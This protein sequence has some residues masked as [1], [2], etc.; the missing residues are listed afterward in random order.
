[1]KRQANPKTDC[2]TDISKGTIK[3]RARPRLLIFVVAF[4]AASTI[5]DVLA[6]IPHSISDECE[7]E[8]LIID[9][10]STDETFER[11]RAR[12][13]NESFQFPLTLLF[14]PQN[15]GYGG[16]QKIGYFYAIKKGFDFV[17]L[18]HGDGQYAPECLPDLVRPLA[19]GEADAVFGSRM[20]TPGGAR[21]GGMPL[22]KFG[23]NK[24]LTWFENWALRSSLTEF[25]SGYRVYSVAAL[26]KVPFSLNT[27]DFH[28][29]TE[30]IIQLQ[31]A[32]LRIIEIPIPTYYGNELCHVDGVKYAI[33]VTRA[34]LRARAQ[35]F[36]L[37]YD[38]RF[39]V[40]T[41]SKSNAKY[42]PKLDYESTHSITLR[43][44]PSRA[45]VVDLGCAGGYMGVTLKER[46]QCRV[47][48]VDVSPLAAGIKLDGFHQQDLNKGLPDLRWEDFDYVL[49]LDVIEHLSDPEA[50]V[51]LLRSKLERN[52]NVK[53]LVSTG[54][55]AFFVTRMMLLFGQF[56]YGTKG[57][58][59]RTHTR[60][61]TFSTFRRLFE[62]NGFEVLE[63]IG[64]PGPF[65]IAFGKGRLS[66]S[67][68]A[69]NKRLVT[70]F[71]G[72]FSYQI[73]FVVRP[74]ASLDYLLARAQ[75]QSAVRFAA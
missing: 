21:A 11:V 40:L 18:V 55:V 22:Y 41:D 31:L 69:I 61:F 19:R 52:P 54:N 12:L 75:E 57:I 60:L 43:R 30:I 68:M 71:R 38:A 8:L 4:N 29:D 20:M 74:R 72:V 34:V 66:R 44:V 25:H 9:D 48:G 53:V 39:D 36:G 5:G 23:G 58:L 51:Q 3:D 10:A 6:R 59:D 17:A 14:N 50:F 35:D 45:R 62:Q 2:T 63:T 27:N 56:N 13:Q 37:L 28:F 26:R 70:L 32:R 24:I 47:V 67:L 1:M 15:Q 46:A 49:L 73:Y 7:V 42:T 65:A 16:N 33:N 64:V